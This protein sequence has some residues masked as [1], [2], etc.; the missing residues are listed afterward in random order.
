M[1]T[2]TNSTIKQIE[3]RY[4]D[5]AKKIEQPVLQYTGKFADLVAPY[6][7]TRPSFLESVPSVGDAIDEGL[8]FRNRVVAEQTAFVRNLI[9]ALEPVAVSYNGKTVAA[10]KPAAKAKVHAA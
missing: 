1:A 3:D 8:K 4:F 5:V 10:P 2:T 7:R 6:V 9:K